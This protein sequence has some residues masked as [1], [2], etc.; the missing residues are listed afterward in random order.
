MTAIQNPIITMQLAVIDYGDGTDHDGIVF[1][2]QGENGERLEIE[3]TNFISLATAVNGFNW[4]Q[5][6]AD[7][8]TEEGMDEAIEFTHKLAERGMKMS[9]TNDELYEFL[10]EPNE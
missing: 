4:A 3:F 1:S 8:L 10:E 6:L 5:A 9:F 2:L 7:I